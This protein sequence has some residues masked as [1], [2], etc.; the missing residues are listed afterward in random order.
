M[1]PIY[2]DSV[3]SE[4]SESKVI[5]RKWLLFASGICVSGILLVIALRHQ[6]VNLVLAPKYRSIVDLLPWLALGYACYSISFIYENVFY[7]YNKTVVIFK[8]NILMA[9]ITVL[10]TLIMT[11]TYGLSGAAISVVI[12]NILKLVLLRYC[13]LKTVN[14][15]L[16]TDKI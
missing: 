4:S 15:S 16:N 14:Q 12:I 3:A 9:V 2:F 7:A 11:C 6:I 5:L 10:A 8:I 13:S 1:R